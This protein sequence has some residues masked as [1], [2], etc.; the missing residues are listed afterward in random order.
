[1]DKHDKVS[2]VSC[3]NS[4]S[5]S[6]T[7]S[8]RKDHF[9]LRMAQFSKELEQR[10]QRDERAARRALEAAKR[11]ADAVRKRAEEEV[12]ELEEKIKNDLKMKKIEREIDLAEARAKAWD[13][14][15]SPCSQSKK[16]K[17][18]RSHHSGSDYVKQ[19]LCQ[20]GVQAIRPSSLQR[21]NLGDPPNLCPQENQEQTQV[22]FGL[23]HRYR[24]EV[25]NTPYTDN[26]ARVYEVPNYGLDLRQATAPTMPYDYPPPRPEIVTFD[27]DPL[28]YISF[29]SSFQ[30]HIINRVASDNARMTYLLQYC[31]FNVKKMI[32]HYL[33]THQGFERA[34]AKVHQLFGRPLIIANR[35]EE[36]LLSFGRVKG[37][38]S[39]RLKD[40]AGLMD[41]ALFQIQGIETF[42]SLNSL[43]TLRRI[44]DKLPDKIR[45]DW[46]EWS[47]SFTQETKR[48]VTFRDLALFVRRE[49]DKA[50]SVFG[51]AQWLGSS[52]RTE[53]GYKS[54]RAVVSNSS[55]VA[56]E[57]AEAKTFHRKSKPCEFCNQPHH[58]TQCPKFVTLR[59]FKRMEFV[60]KRGLCF[61]CLS[62]GHQARS[63]FSKITCG[64]EGCKFPN[65]HSLLHKETLVGVNPESITTVLS[66][67]KRTEEIFDE[68][69]P[70]LPILPVE[71]ICGEHRRETY[72]LLDTGSQQTFCST[73]LL[74]ALEAGGRDCDLQIR[75]MGAP[76]SGNCISGK[77]VDLRV[78]ALGGGQAIDLDNVI[79][80]D[81]MP[82][83]KCLNLTNTNLLKWY[84][85]RDL[86]LPQITDKSV[87][88]LIGIDC[89]RV[90][91]PLE[92]RIGPAKA[93]DAVR[94]PLRWVLYGANV[95]VGLA[96][97]SNHAALNV[98]IDVLRDDPCP[99]D[100]PEPSND[101]SC[102]LKTSR[103]DRIALQMM[104]EKV[105]I[106]NGHFQ[107]PLLWESSTSQLPNNRKVAEM[108]LMC[109]KGR[110]AKDKALHEKYSAVMAS[111]F[112]EGYAE[113]IGVTESKFSWFLPHHPVVNPMKPDKL[114]IVFDCG[115]EY[116]GA[117]LNKA[118]IRGPDLTN[119]LVGVLLRFREKG[120]TLVADVKSMFHQVKVEPEDKNVLKFL[121]WP[122]GNMDEFP[123][124]CCMTVHIFG[125]KSSPSCASFAL[126]HAVD[127]FGHEFSDEAVT[128]V[129]RNFYV[130][131]FLLSVSSISE[132]VQIGR[133]VTKMLSKAGFTLH[134]WL[135][136]KSEVTKH[137]SEISR[138]DSSKPISDKSQMMHR[139]L[140]VQW[141]VGSDRFRMQVDPSVKA[142]TRRGLLSMVSSI[143]DP[144]GFVAPIL[145]APKL[146]LRELKEQDWDEEI[147]EDEQ[148]R[149][150]KWMASLERL[151]AVHIDRCISLTSGG[152]VSYELHHFSDAS[153][154]AYGAVSYLRTE[155][156]FGS[157]KVAFLMGKGYLAKENRT[158]PQLELMAAV[159]SVRLDCLIRKEL[160]LPVGSSCYWCDST[161]TL[162]S[163]KN[164]T[165]RFPVFTANRL[166]VIER[167]SDPV[168]DWRYVPSALNPADE[169]SRGLS[170]KR[171]VNSNYWISGPDFLRDSNMDWPEDICSEI[172]PKENAKQQTTVAAVK[173]LV[174]KDLQPVDRLVRSFS[175]LHKVKGTTAWLLRFCAYLTD[176]HC[177]K[178]LRS[179]GPLTYSE[180]NHAER[181]LI[182]YEQ[183][184]FLPALHLS[185][186]TKGTVKRSDCSFAL[187]KGS[188]KLD[189]DL[190]VMEG[191]L[192]NAPT[193]LSFN[194][195]AES[196]LTTLFVLQCHTKCGHGG[197]CH[198]FTELRARFWIEKSSSTIRKVINN[199]LVCR[200]VKAKCLTQKMS[201]LPPARMQIFDPPFSHTGVDFF[202]PLLVKQGRSNVKRYGC[203]F[204]CL[205][206]R[207]I[208]LELAFDL[209]TDSFLNVLRRF[210]ARRR[211]IRHLYSD[212]GTNFVGAEKLLRDEYT[213]YDQNRVRDQMA[214]AGIEWT[215][216]PPLASHFGGAWE[217]MIRTI[218]KIL[219]TI[220]PGPVY[221]EDVIRTVLIDIEAMI[222]SR[223]LTPVIFHDVEERPLTPN[224]LL[225]PD[226]NSVIPLPLSDDRDAY[227]KNKYKQ[228]KFLI[229]RARE[230][231]LK[232]YLPTI[233]ERSKWFAEKRNLGVN[234]IVILTKDPT[235]Q[236]M[237]ELGVVRKVFPD[238]KGL[239]RSVLV[240]C[241]D[242]TLQRP[243]SKLKLFLPAEEI[244]RTSIPNWLK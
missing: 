121:W 23:P 92:C 103:E 47:F 180:L 66:A 194:F 93:P 238:N 87:G 61:R 226:A 160:S 147:S 135:S 72:A 80:V 99:L 56:L 29:A 22:H 78:R 201:D 224:D 235:A 117:S 146:W 32:D 10:K 68:S 141:N 237:F 45:E 218:R 107:L 169:V 175:S 149:W 137:F 139:V 55:V 5:Q 200:K 209:S 211:S 172:V 21:L 43:G 3:S 195:P 79:S 199:C 28:N 53:G 217:R 110:L 13:E 232:E 86:E 77:L 41:K 123:E 94:T 38:D 84:H 7:S 129:R 148:R 57:E 233:A 48:E 174:S 225:M 186:K 216:N 143:F 193:S 167:H 50:C 181:V 112:E 176:K 166:A 127:V 179:A 205:T 67:H 197:V 130:D 111:Y 188:P 33:G 170:V 118:L 183:R 196:H 102:S 133:E 221:S 90:F 64:T 229:N 230:R 96:D 15:S 178:T 39:E 25:L 151:M 128:A 126:L 185:L 198:T 184:K 114:R 241:Q 206:T 168:K 11:E 144:L 31:N 187:L 30:T 131:D 202:G 9:D 122:E 97:V 215:F 27:G 161:A 18:R 182:A 98:S 65:H 234:D 75:T 162:Y 236:H 73:S 165:K 40:F 150:K 240:K 140:G 1:M 108:R 12:K 60:K 44:V 95:T 156:E 8:K 204:T 164:R 163:I 192:R 190:I 155:D 203:I 37:R 134:K 171:F 142:F 115:A 239:V 214:I 227:I 153:S 207:A 157:I 91:Q 213:K 2:S 89:K 16:A 124:V 136:N 208:H 177:K 219:T 189:N 244:D 191:R 113:K 26:P 116:N 34:W 83:E 152:E 100:L 132:A 222:N 119:T 59:H 105:K 35:C 106:V 158:I 76:K 14:V 74:L 4:A 63:C 36:M 70:L 85:L 159:V 212:N 88:L 101:C 154:Y 71:V 52:D 242:K 51:R 17:P 104:K 69:L 24:P 81:R 82:V 109:L 125:A 42:S 20:E 243:I 46:A 58:L 19:L 120:V 173:N 54:K 138:M 231:W 228:T 210:A 145:T 62:P 49:A 220:S 6:A 223:P